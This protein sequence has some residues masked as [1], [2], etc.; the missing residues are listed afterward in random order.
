MEI[1]QNNI[2]QI[3]ANKHTLTQSWSMVVVL[4]M[5]IKVM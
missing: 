4:H 5:H 2:K 1:K 3:K